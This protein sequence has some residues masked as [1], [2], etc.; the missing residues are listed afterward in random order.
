MTGICGGTRQLRGCFEAEAL[1]DVALDVGVD[2]GGN[3][4]V[5][6]ALGQLRR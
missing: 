3:A 1:Q 6:E 2:N 4:G 5:L